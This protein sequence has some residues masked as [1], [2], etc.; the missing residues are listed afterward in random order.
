MERLGEKV[1]GLKITEK[2]KAKAKFV[3][4]RKEALAWV[5]LTNECMRA[6]NRLL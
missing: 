3:A 2:E 5:R 4:E 6:Q 1:A